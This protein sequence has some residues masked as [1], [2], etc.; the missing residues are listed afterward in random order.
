ME[1]SLVKEIKE[2]CN[3]EDE[4]GCMIMMDFMKAYDRVD[5]G[6]MIKTLRA[7]NFGENSFK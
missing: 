3:E 7:M 2:Y 5:R 6:A 1:T 4:E